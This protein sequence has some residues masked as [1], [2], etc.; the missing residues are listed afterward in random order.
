MHTRLPG[1]IALTFVSVFSF[2][3][4]ADDVSIRAESRI[5]AVTVYSDRAKV[6]RVAEVDV[7]K[8][9]HTIVFDNLPRGLFT[10]SLRAEGSS[11][12]PVTFGAVAHKEVTGAELSVERERELREKLEELQDRQAAI[13]AE[14]H[15]I[16]ARKSFITS[17]GQTATLRNN[18]NLS[19]F[20]LK[21]A[22]WAAAAGAI[23]T[24]TL[25]SM[26]ATLDLDIKNRSLSKE[27]AKI[28][29]DLAKIGTGARATYSVMIPIEAEAAGRL[30]VS[31]SYQIA[32]A[33]WQPVY[34]AR[35]DTSEKGG[36]AL[37]QY[38]TVRQSTGEDWKDVALAL[39]TAQPQRGTSLP[40]LQPMWVNAYDHRKA[41][42]TALQFSSSAMDGAAMS[43]Y[44]PVA[45]EK[46]EALDE[47]KSRA[48]TRRFEMEP[49]AA[50]FAAATIETGGFV[51]EYAIPGPSNVP[52]DGTETRLMVG[53][54]DTGSKLEI[55]VKPQISTDA[56]LVSVATLK[57]EAP[58]LP[59]KVSLFRDGA[60][61]GAGRLPL[62]RAGEEQP[63]YF[64]IDDNVA[65]KR[66]TLKDERREQ[67]VISAETVLERRYVTE[68]QNLHKS[69]V[70]LV[71]K[72]TVPAPQNEQVKLALAKDTTPG[73]ETDAANIKGLLQWSFRMAAQEKKDVTLGW[74]LAWPKDM[75]LSGLR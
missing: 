52:A 16:E 54:F 59:G 23:F 35:L 60:Y 75:E 3:A 67:G 55:H 53:T 30:A 68:I 12:V 58:A 9:A 18:E 6:T 64:G 7:P 70:T 27:I 34:D 63:L 69:D 47:W 51:T 25:A 39:S 37:I 2:T 20:N 11:R 29:S 46:A 17:I 57:G 48:V 42:P 32:N 50:K 14:K 71:V 36:L 45:A 40:D 38:G 74:S 43:N 19:E 73:F 28:Q 22:E 49:A 41:A 21:P 5:A 61:V 72:E 66:K 24:E 56:Y 13:N 65:V 10:D 31:L 15:A 33:T 44:A 62:L 26:K 8:G 1:L 4:F